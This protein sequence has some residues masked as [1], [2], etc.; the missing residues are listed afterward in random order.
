MIDGI[1][2]AADGL[3]AYAKN[4][5]V[6]ARNLANVNTVGFKRNIIDFKTVLAEFGA[7]RNESLQA[8]VGIDF[9]KGVHNYTGNSLDMAID[10]D[11]FFTIE[12][13]QGLRYTRNG[14][15]Q[16][17]DNGE[18]VTLSGGKLLGGGGPL[19]I[20]RG[21][22]EIKIDSEGVVKV[23]EGREIGTILINN[24][25]DTSVLVPAGA[26]LF[27]ASFEASQN[28]GD[29]KIAQGYLE[30]SN[31]N[32]VMEMVNMISNMR[33]HESSNNIMKTFSDTI[34]R[35]IDTQSNV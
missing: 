13:E 25:E 28:T 14:Q 5:E 32:I 16:L 10:G 33:S 19:V 7:G 4:Q 18:I 21:N 24:F 22:S 26:G 27:K 11:G 17:S 3:E 1:F 31:V 9:S 2:K 8:N 30:N 35:L 23:G 12:T 34:K 29:F 20:P 6:I 15:F